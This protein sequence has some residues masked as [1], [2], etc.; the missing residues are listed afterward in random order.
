MQKCT[1]LLIP[2]TTTLK[3]IIKNKLSFDLIW[4]KLF[5]DD[6]FERVLLQNLNKRKKKMREFDKTSKVPY[7]QRNWECT[8]SEV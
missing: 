4:N 3:E 1:K 7:S 5:E 2:L 6:V 8:S